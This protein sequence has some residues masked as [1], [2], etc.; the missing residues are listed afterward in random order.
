MKKYLPITTFWV[1]V[2]LTI[3]GFSVT[4]CDKY[5]TITFD[6]RTAVPIKVILY[7]VSKDYADIPTRAWNDPGAVQ[8]GSGESKA[9][10]TGVWYK[11][12]VEK[13]VVIAVTEANEVVLSKVST[14]DELHDANWKIVIQ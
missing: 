9:Y 8:I 14:W 13:Y 1:V 4:G 12:V 6:N 10:V 2:M 7:R 5:Q 11:R 3:F